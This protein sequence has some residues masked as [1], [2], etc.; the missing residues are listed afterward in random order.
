MRF[1]FLLLCALVFAGCEDELPLP[2]SSTAGKLVL[3][4]EMVAGELFLIRVGQSAAMTTGTTVQIPEGVTLTVADEDGG[5]WTAAGV[6]DDLSEELH[7]VSFSTATAA[8]PGQ[9]YT[10]TARHPALGEASA[11][12]DIPQQFAATL[13]D[14]VRAQHAGAPVLRASIRIDDAPGDHYYIIEAV[15]QPMN[16]AHEF[17]FGG[18]W[19]DVT[20]DPFLYDSLRTAGASFPERRD[21][22]FSARS[23]RV[24][25]YTDDAATENVLNGSTAPVAYRRVLLSDRTFAGRAYTT[26]VAV[27][28][29]AFVAFY[30]E[31]RGRV[32]LQ[33]KSVSKEYFDFLARYER[34]APEAAAEPDAL[35]GNVVGGYGAVGGVARVEW[36]WVFD[37]FE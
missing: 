13:T 37:G 36:M 34:Y 20:L 24:L 9:R 23:S 17:F 31:D 6:R 26:T 25:L 30:P 29:D 22:T 14:T 27:R 15:K 28:S 18:R 4:G 21:T 33:L 11:V 32:R 19:C 1:A 3:V 5:T 35:Q 2:A 7:T 16:V 12:V 10:L 8:V